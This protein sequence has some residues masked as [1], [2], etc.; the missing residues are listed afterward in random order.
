LYLNEPL[1][2]V[3]EGSDEGELLVVRRALSGLA[4]QEDNK[5]REAIFHTRCTIGGKV[6]SLFIDGRCCA[7]VASKTMVDK[8]KLSATPHP[9]P[10]PYNGL[11][12]TKVS[13]FLPVVYS[14]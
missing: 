10:A 9:H 6:C 4:A 14:L 3:I 8:L 13:K 7:N 11:I 12:M 1:E 5:Q 2:E